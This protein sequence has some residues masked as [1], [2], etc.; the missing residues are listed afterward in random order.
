MNVIANLSTLLI[1]VGL[2]E[3]SYRLLGTERGFI[4]SDCG[5]DLG[6]PAWLAID[7]WVPW[8]YRVE[9]L[10]GYTPELFFGITMA[11]MLIVMSCI[12]LLVTF[13]VF[14]ASIVRLKE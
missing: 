9:T 13:A 12:L 3:L 4:F 11:E 6:L 1:A 7:E 8:L 14:F 10:C 2:T 5:L